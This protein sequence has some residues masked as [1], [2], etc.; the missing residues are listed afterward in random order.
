MNS[1]NKN[2]KISITELCG[3]ALI[4]ALGLLAMGQVPR[5]SA[6]TEVL[7]FDTTRAGAPVDASSG[8]FVGAGLTQY[9]ADYGITVSSADGTPAIF[10]ETVANSSA[11]FIPS[12]KPNFFSLATFGYDQQTVTLRLD[13]A[14]PVVSISFIRVGF[15]SLSGNPLDHP[16]YTVTPIQTP[17]GEPEVDLP[18][19]IGD[20]SFGLASAP[21]SAAP[22]LIADS[23]I[24][25]FGSGDTFNAVEIEV[26]RG[27]VEGSI[28]GDV[29]RE[30]DFEYLG[31]DDLTITYVP[32]PSTA[33]LLLLA[34]VA[35]AC[36][37]TYRR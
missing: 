34:A 18:Q 20:S 15:N 21:P 17:S 10:P 31:I 33:M 22:S 19:S 25:A 14:Q 3:K 23:E 13:F 35:G 5:A 9:F 4:L 36:R 29:I 6:F 16:A 8:S 24:I 12:S 1:F 2:E 28:N 11:T 37:R 32:E 7:N 26:D 30:A 27:A